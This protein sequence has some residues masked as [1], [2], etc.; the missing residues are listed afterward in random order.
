MSESTRN[1]LIDA[2]LAMF[3]EDGIDGPSLRAITRAAGQRNTGALQYHF[4]DRDELLRQA[5]E[6]RG[7]GA[8]QARVEMLEAMGA[9]ATVREMATALVEPLADLL[10][11]GG[12][13]YLL[14][15]DEVLARP[16]R[17]G[18]LYPVVVE[19]PGLVEWAKLVEPHMPAGA[20]GRPLHR[21][22]A[23]IRFAHSE[24]ANR[25]RNKAGRTG[26]AL[27]SSHLIDLAA[28]IVV[29]PISPETDGLIRR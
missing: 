20:I 8:D 13:D 7:A 21:R 10:G 4:G 15:A 24:L 16:L 12:R 22:F 25:S 14:V 1:D 29:A 3:A 19:R 26:L 6:L 2:A 27:F 5:L 17:F 23:A 11:A 28:A 9:T 18:E